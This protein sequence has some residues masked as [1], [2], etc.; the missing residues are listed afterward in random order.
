MPLFAPLSQ[1]ERRALRSA[2]A[3]AVPQQLAAL[4]QHHHTRV[5]D[6]FRALDKN[7]DG[8]VT[9]DELESALASLGVRASKGELN[10]L[11]ERLDPDGSG[12]IVF[13]ELQLAMIEA[14]REEALRSYTLSAAYAAFEE[15]Q[16]GSIEP[17]K[18]ADLVVLEEDPRRVEP[19]K[20][21][22]ISIS[23]TWMNGRQV[24]GA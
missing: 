11:F 22:D 19:R 10:E 5:I 21:S 8:E 3:H 18:L 7:A 1:A 13:R 20:I 24:Y 14:T 4:L 2:P 16:K 15:D 12:G 17:G 9:R 6:L 23:Q